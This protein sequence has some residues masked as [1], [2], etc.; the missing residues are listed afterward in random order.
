M[1]TEFVCHK[2]GNMCEIDVGDFPKIICWCDV[3]LDYAQGLDEDEYAGEYLAARID[4]TMDRN[5]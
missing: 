5:K 1:E 4:D 2:C 3:C